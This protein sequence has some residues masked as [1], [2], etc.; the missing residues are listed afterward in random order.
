MKN[1]SRITLITCIGALTAFSSCVTKE[2]KIII[3]APATAVNVDSLM[4]LWNQGWNTKDTI[5]LESIIAEN[6]FVMMGNYE[7][8]G[9]DSIMQNWVRQNIPVV[10]NLQ[11]TSRVI[12]VA[13]DAAWYTGYY[14]LD[15]VIDGEKTGSEE[16]NLT[17]VWRKQ[18]DASWKLEVMHMGS[19]KD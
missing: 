10:A 9:R 15:V 17:F 13:G 3:Q 5:L 19:L 2:E 18:A 11:T 14:T 12:T 6:G 1:I 4:G 8:A 16:G 7:L